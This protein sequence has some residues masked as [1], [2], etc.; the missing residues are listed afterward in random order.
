MKKLFL[1]PIVLL[2]LILTACPKFEQN[3]RD[4][5][6]A[7]GGAVTAA[8]AQHQTEC[9]ATPT[10]PTCALINRAVAGQNALITSI[11]AYCGWTAGVLPTDPNAACVPVSGAKAGLQTAIDNANVFI[12]QLKGVIQ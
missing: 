2:S 8:Q 10:S 1:V 11:E 9:T 4:T 6:A 5:A 7:L 12:G 3:A